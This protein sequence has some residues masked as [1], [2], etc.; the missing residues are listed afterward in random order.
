MKDRPLPG[1]APG[2]RRPPVRRMPAVRLLHV[3]VPVP[4]GVTIA[5]SAAGNACGPGTALE[6]A[7]VLAACCAAAAA[8]A[9]LL[10][11]R[12]LA[13]PALESRPRARA[14]VPGTADRPSLQE[15]AR[16]PGARAAP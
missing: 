6:V 3:T 1:R 7:A 9:C 14:R 16:R 2:P 13:P 10:A 15:N 12:R 4:A 11:V 8:L 5:V